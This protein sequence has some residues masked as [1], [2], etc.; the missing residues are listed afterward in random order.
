MQNWIILAIKTEN[1]TKQISKSV[2]IG[3][4]TKQI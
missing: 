3:P 1:E 2:C 4:E